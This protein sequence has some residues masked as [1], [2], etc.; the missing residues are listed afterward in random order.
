MICFEGKKTSFLR[1][2]PSAVSLVQKLKIENFCGKGEQPHKFFIFILV[3]SH[4]VELNISVVLLDNK[5]L[6]FIVK[7]TCSTIH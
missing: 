5:L 4:D 1:V 3:R 6:C 2:Y 7:A